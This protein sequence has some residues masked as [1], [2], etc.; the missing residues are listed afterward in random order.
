MKL[1]TRLYLV[2]RLRISGAVP[3]LRL[4]SFMAGIGTNLPVLYAKRESARE[5]FLTGQKCN[6]SDTQ[7]PYREQ[8]LCAHCPG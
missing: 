8:Q 3:L 7:H 1:T 6:R 2:S 4:Y 5:T